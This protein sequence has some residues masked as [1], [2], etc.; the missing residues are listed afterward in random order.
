MRSALLI[1]ELRRIKR[2]FEA[3][4]SQYHELTLTI[5]YLV[6]GKQASDL[7][8]P[9]PHYAINLWQFVGYGEEAVQ[10]LDRTVFGLRNA[11]LTAL[12]VIAG[13][14]TERFRSM[15]M[16]AGSLLPD[17]ARELLN[18]GIVKQISKILEEDDPTF[19]ALLPIFSSNSNPFAVW[20]NVMLTAVV[21]F[22]PERF[23]GQRLAVDP[24]TASLVALDYLLD[25][26][27]DRHRTVQPVAANPIPALEDIVEIKPSFMGIGINLRA[28]VRWL[29]RW[30]AS[31]RKGSGTTHAEK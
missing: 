16:R 23:Q 10:N 7:V 17:E 27:E 5:H 21:T 15:A 6:K 25:V 3:H 31:R 2:D 26:L 1:E 12:G 11:E 8:L 14:H 22:Q 13:P 24:F 4:A 9:R 20:L 19:G 30:R 18:V 28:L 29:S